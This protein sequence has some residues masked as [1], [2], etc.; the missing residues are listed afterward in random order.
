MAFPG[1]F[2]DV[3]ALKIHPAIG[4]ARI[5]NSDEHYVFGAPQA[6]Y[7]DATKH[8]KRQAV[9]F[10]I[11]AYGAGNAV[12]GELTAA[13]MSQL[14]ISAVWRARV[15]N[16]KAAFWRNVPL[17]STNFV[18]A[19][20][21]SSDVNDGK[22]VGSIPQF[23]EGAAIPL[24]QITNDGLF[25]PPKGGVYRETPGTA[26]PPY[27]A[28]S[29]AM[30]DTASDGEISVTLSGVAD[31]PAVLPACILV[32]PQDFSP[33]VGSSPNLYRY[34]AKRIGVPHTA[35]ASDPVALDRAALA[36]CTSDF[37]P[38]YEI[39]LD[40]DR[41]EVPDVRDVMFPQDVRIRY[42]QTHGDTGAVPGQ[43][44]SGLCSPWQGDFTA[45]VGYWAE[46]LPP[47]A[48]LEADT[49]QSVLVFRRNYDDLGG[50][51]PWLT[52]GDD[53]DRHVDRIG[54]VRVRNGVIVETE[55]GPGDDF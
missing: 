39:G 51:G 41:T 9:Q 27:P 30:V 15:A 26:I 54:T 47:D 20:S 53:F 17:D 33:D 46:N 13:V 10:R 52:S 35:P 12:L 28:R 32:A 23:A 36:S 7:K 55:R 48:Q 6:T 45:C 29:N 31:I 8:I 25:I 19:A 5:S 40:P 22:L 24:G 44:T 34:L 49:S 16:R 11:F 1:D 43:L 4:V 2:T 38:G 3:V 18:A 42:K 37:N 21:A 50:T 14:G